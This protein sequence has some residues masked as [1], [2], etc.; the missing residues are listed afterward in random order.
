ME[1]SM[2]KRKIEENNKEC[3]KCTKNAKSQTGLKNPVYK[4]HRIWY[5]K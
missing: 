5:L 2:R 1:L 4:F 3:K